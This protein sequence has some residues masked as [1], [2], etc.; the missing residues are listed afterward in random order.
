MGGV[1]LAP[2]RVDAKMAFC[3][4]WMSTRQ[5]K[6]PF[7]GKTLPRRRAECTQGTFSVNAANQ[8]SDPFP[9]A[10]ILQITYICFRENGRQIRPVMKPGAGPFRSGWRSLHKEYHF[11][12]PFL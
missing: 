2:G 7:S 4:F 12:A 9:L 1:S 6:Q 3:A 10:F 11:S 5:G 8:I